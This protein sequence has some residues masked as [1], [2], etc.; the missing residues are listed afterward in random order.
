MGDKGPVDH[1]PMIMQMMESSKSDMQALMSSQATQ[2]QSSQQMMMTMMMT[3]M[4]E[5]GKSN[6]AMVTA[7]AARPETPTPTSSMAEMM[8]LFLKMMEMKAGGGEGDFNKTLEAVERIQELTNG[9]KEDEGT[10][11]K[12]GKIAAGLFGGLMP[13]AAGGVLPPPAPQIDQPRTEPPY[14]TE[15]P[16]P[17]TDMNLLQ[18]MQQKIEEAAMARYLEQVLSAAERDEDPV[19]IANSI[20]M[21]LGDNSE[22][23]ISVL[24][25]PAWCATLFGEDPRSVNHREWLEDLRIEFLALYQPDEH[26]ETTIIQPGD[27]E[28]ADSSGGSTSSTIT[29]AQPPVSSDT[30]DSGRPADS[31]EAI[32]PTE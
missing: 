5:A 26:D 12:I 20:A 29:P 22:K 1:M 19:M 4:T 8:P 24:T 17:A 27:S 13:A 18:K 11:G 6:S 9:G 7:I 23:L 30:G 32:E 16:A 28:H 15:E 25:E 3:M 31:P 21:S 10:L 2:Q 14:P